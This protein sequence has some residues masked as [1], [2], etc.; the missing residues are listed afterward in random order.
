MAKG[1]IPFGHSA[2]DQLVMN[3]L[4]RLGVDHRN[5]LGYD[6]SRDAG[7]SEITLRMIFDDQPAG[8]VLP[9]TTHQ[10]GL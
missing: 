4:Q 8:D 6:I 5:V 10:E 1:L 3:F 9:A 2:T 7:R